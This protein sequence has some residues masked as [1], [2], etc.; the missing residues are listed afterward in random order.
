MNTTTMAP[1]GAEKK[2]RRGRAPADII[3]PEGLY[4]WAAFEDRIPYSRETWR[5]RV[6]NGTAPPPQVRT[7]IRTAWR[8]ADLLKWLEDPEG[9][10]VPVA[11]AGE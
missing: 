5:K 11:K 2:E 9:Y 1:A 4:P 6:N 3:R 7:T 10:Q 8:G